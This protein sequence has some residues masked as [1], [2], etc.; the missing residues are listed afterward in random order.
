MTIIRGTFAKKIGITVIGAILI[1][2]GCI[3]CAAKAKTNI[4]DD[5]YRNYYEVFVYSFY[6]S[7]GDGIG[8]LKGVDEKLSYIADMGFN[9]IWL[10]PIMESPTYHKYDVIDYKKIDPEYGSLEDMKKLIENAHNNDI[11][12]IIDLAIN[13]S[14]SQN[15]WF[16]EACDYLKKLPKDKN[17]SMDEIIA[18]CPYV[19]YYHFTKEPLSS[20]YYQVDGT[21]FYYEGEFWSEMP[22]LNLS[23][24]ELYKELEDI[25][26]FWIKDVGVDGFRMDAVTHF[27]E[28]DTAYN[29]D[30]LNR[31]YSYCKSLNP[32]FYMVSEAWT[33]ESSIADYYGSKT[34]SFFNFDLAGAEGKLIKCASGRGNMPTLINAMKNYEEEFGLNHSEYIDAPFITNHDMTRVYNALM[35]D[36]AAIKYAGGLLMSMSGSPFVYYGEEIGLMSKGTADENKRLPMKWDNDSYAEATNGH[37]HG[38]I[39]ADKDVTQNFDGVKEQLQDENSILNYYKKALLIRN[40]NPEIARGS[41]LINEEATEGKHALISKTYKDSTITIIYNNDAA[42][43]YVIGLEEYGLA[44]NAIVGFLTVDNSKIEIDSGKII[45]PARSIVYL[46]TK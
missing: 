20:A 21:D 43:E 32:N 33:S 46:K 9:G 44:D 1:L 16:K 40:Q 6:D 3:G 27:E 10:M 34:D 29:I 2:A 35:G 30:I 36:E 15:A 37:C 11:R 39:D 45:M 28:N 8:D 7:D 4:I 13:H 23:S 5:N 41:I 25:A 14:S 24:D 38:P 31:F 22:D 18:G 26:S 19:D 17:I 42:E 12:V